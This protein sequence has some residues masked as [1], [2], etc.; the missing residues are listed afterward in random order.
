MQSNTSPPATA[1]PTTKYSINSKHYLHIPPLHHTHKQ[2]NTITML[3]AGYYNLKNGS[4]ASS[5]SASASPSAAASRR[6]SAEKTASINSVEGNNAEYQPT[7]EVRRSSLKKALD[8][9]RPASSSGSTTSSSGPKKEKKLIWNMS[10][11]QYEM[12]SAAA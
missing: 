11:A 6:A 8:K 9:L 5:P 12:F 4:A 1:S 3:Y 2:P 7:T 10:R